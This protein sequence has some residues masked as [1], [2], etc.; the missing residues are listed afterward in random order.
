MLNE[1]STPTAEET[2]NRDS[3][4]RNNGNRS[5]T[6]AANGNAFAHFTAHSSVFAGSF[7][8]RRT[9]TWASSMD[10]S[11]PCTA[12]ARGRA[13]SRCRRCPSR[14]CRSHNGS[15]PPSSKMF[16]S[17]QPALH[18]AAEVVR[19]RRGCPRCRGGTSE[20]G[21]APRPCMTPGSACRANALEALGLNMDSVDWKNSQ[22][23]SNR[24]MTGGYIT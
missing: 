23:C 10:S 9:A 2:A 17:L 24:A 11:G 4:N 19:A 18:L 20:S 16:T 21:P 22:S 13:R 5:S 8:S 3:N 12:G 7:G 6:E 1:L 15:R 14:S